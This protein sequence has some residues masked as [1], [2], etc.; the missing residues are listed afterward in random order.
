MNTKEPQPTSVY[1]YKGKFITTW[2]N[3]DITVS[4]MKYPD[5]ESAKKAIDKILNNNLMIGRIK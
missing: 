5:F 2:D 4:M 1:E 3:Q